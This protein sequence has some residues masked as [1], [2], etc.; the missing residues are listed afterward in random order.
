[1]KTLPVTIKCA[2]CDDLVDKNKAEIDSFDRDY[3]SE[4]CKKSRL[5]WE[6]EIK[7]DVDAGRVN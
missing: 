4:E 2:W 7:K 3:C 6:E 1:M 5:D